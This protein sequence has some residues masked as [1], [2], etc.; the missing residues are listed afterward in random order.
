MVYI[1]K[2]RDTI[3]SKLQGQEAWQ[4]NLQYELY[5]QE[6]QPQNA[7]TQ[8]QGQKHDI[9]EALQKK[10]KKKKKQL[11]ETKNQFSMNT[12]SYERIL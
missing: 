7:E 12:T 1:T 10:K 2:E 5:V 8:I 3:A 6:Q 4:I 11:L 9:D